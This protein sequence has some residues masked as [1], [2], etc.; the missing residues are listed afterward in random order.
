MKKRKD[1]AKKSGQLKQ[2]S[3]DYT[4]GQISEKERLTMKTIN[5]NSLIK[6]NGKLNNRKVKQEL[7]KIQ[8]GGFRHFTIRGDPEKC[9]PLCDRISDTQSCY[10]G[11]TCRVCI[12]TYKPRQ[13]PTIESKKNR[14]LSK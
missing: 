14:P 10:G 11:W 1:K 13:G 9:Q 5:G 12:H 7:K 6:K 2:K 4:L 8:R 3:P